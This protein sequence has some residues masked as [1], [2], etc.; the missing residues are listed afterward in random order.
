MGESPSIADLRAY[1]ELTQLKLLTNHF[2]KVMKE[3]PLIKTWY[4]KLESHPVIQENAAMINIAIEKL[5]VNDE[6]LAT[7]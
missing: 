1:E 3:N 2:A 4:E 5:A 6:I 7:E